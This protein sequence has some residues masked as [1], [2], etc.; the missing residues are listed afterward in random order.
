MKTC[1]IAG[2][3]RKVSTGLQNVLL[4]LICTRY[5][6]IND[7]GKLPSP[8]SKLYDDYICYF[9]CIVAIDFEFKF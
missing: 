2:L 1:N 5:D 8:M 7:V 4:K 9:R 3:C 6:V